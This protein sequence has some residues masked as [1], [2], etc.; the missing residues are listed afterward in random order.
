M[1]RVRKDEV[2]GDKMRGEDMRLDETDYDYAWRGS[3][4]FGLR[5]RMARFREV[6]TTTTHG[7][8]QR[9]SDYDYA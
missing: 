3:E 1:V 5:L 2:R 8:V 4:R 6:R 7:E 9:G